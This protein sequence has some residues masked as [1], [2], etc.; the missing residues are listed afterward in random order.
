MFD[1]NNI[2]LLTVTASIA[3]VYTGTHMACSILDLT[4]VLTPIILL[5]VGASCVTVYVETYM[6]PLILGPDWRFSSAGIQPNFH[7]SK[8]EK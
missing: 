7:C 1:T 2:I 3:T 8:Q 4:D 6:G 5:T